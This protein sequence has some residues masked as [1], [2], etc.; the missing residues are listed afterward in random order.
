LIVHGFIGKLLFKRERDYLQVQRGGEKRELPCVGP[1]REEKRE[2]E[3][4]EDS[5][6]VHHK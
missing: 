4:E 1:E 2:K 6:H 5:L 3:E